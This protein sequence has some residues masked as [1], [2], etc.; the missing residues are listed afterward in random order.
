MQRHPLHAIIGRPAIH[1]LLGVAFAVAFFWPIFAL[2]RPTATFHFLYGAWL[3]ALLA[4]L[5]ISRAAPGS[6]DDGSAEVNDDEP[7]R[8]MF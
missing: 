6:S 2:T 3:I 8:G 5:G 7:T 1:L 4:L